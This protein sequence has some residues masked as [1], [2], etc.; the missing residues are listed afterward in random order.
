M[1]PFVSIIMPVFNCEQYINQALDSILCQSHNDYELIIVNDGS[2]DNTFS[3]L[4]S[5]KDYRIILINE[6]HHGLVSALNRGL[7][8]A[9][10]KY[11]AIMHGDDIASADRL[12]IQI[13]TLEKYPEIGILGS[14]C[15]LIDET[16]RYLGLRNWPTTDLELRW[17]SLLQCPFAH[18]SVMLRREVVK[19]NNLTYNHSFVSVEDYELWTRIFQYT[20]GMNLRKPLLHYRIHT[21]SISSRSK[22]TQIDLHDQVSFRTIRRY[23]PE[24]D[25]TINDVRLLRA[26]FV[27]GRSSVPDLHSQCIRLSDIYLNMLDSFSATHRYKP[28]LKRLRSKVALRVASRILRPPIQ[29]GW[30]QILRRMLNL[31]KAA[32]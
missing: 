3:I 29:N 17:E 2:N 8:R 32:T 28:E 7:H 10:G 21:D 20:S 9:K 30:R 1:K 6:G 16:G 13:Q 23:L 14:S 25:V 26:L 27:G 11:I 5:H 15:Q 18:P 4:A 22:N 31:H 19:K 24:C 12:Q